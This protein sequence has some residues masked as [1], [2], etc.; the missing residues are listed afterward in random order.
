MRGSRATSTGRAVGGHVRP[1]VRSGLL[2]RAAFPLPLLG[3][4]L[5]GSQIATVMTSTR[6]DYGRNRA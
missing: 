2:V 1:A 3:L 5:R 6:D 4:P